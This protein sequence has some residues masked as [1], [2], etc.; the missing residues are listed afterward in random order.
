MS[1]QA[2]FSQ[3][4]PFKA[5]T[6][7]ILNILIHSLYTEREIFLRELISNASDAL[8]R[9]EFEQLTNRDI[10]DPELEL[11]IW[12]SADPDKRTIFIKDTGLGM[13]AEEMMENLGTIAHSG[14][15][16]FLAAAESG[17]SNETKL[18]DIIGQFGVG[19]YSLFMVAESVRVT[20][21]S[22]R[23]D[24]QASAWTSAGDDT[25]TIEPAEKDERG[26]MIEVHLLE[27]ASEFAQENRLREIIHKHS[28]FVPYPIY[29]GSSEEQANERT[30]LWRQIPRQLEEK[31]YDEFY[32]QL[33]LDYDNPLSYTH[34]AADAPVQ[35]YSILYVPS[36]L[37]RG[38]FSLRKEDGLKLYARKILIQ[39]YCKDLL[40]E[41]LQFIQGV[42]DSEDLPLNVSRESIQ[43]NRVME[44]LKRLITSKAIDMLKKLAEED[45]ETYIKF[46]NEFGRHLKQGIAME[47]TDTSE[48]QLL[49]RF[50]TTTHLDSWSSLDDY[51][52]RL[53]DNQTEIYYILG[54]NEQSVLYSPHLDI[55]QKYN[56]E[57]V[58]MT[59]PLDSF[60][61]VRLKE[62]KGHPLRN[63]AQADLKI[64]ETAETASDEE[65]PAIPADE[66]GSLI[67]RFKR[68]LGEKIQDVRMTDRLADSP[69]RL[70]DPEG[71]PN[72]EM[73]RVYKYLQ[74][75]FEMPAKILE[76][77][78]RH[79]ILLKLSKLSEEDNRNAPI[80]DQIYEN[81]L[82]I[83]GLLKDPA[84][85]INR[86]Q[87]IIESALE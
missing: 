47:M 17:K 71:S 66:W 29:L 70:V 81:A 87:Q 67:D 83:E 63:V 10:R 27:D 54:D 30:A 6:K 80:I 86:I 74:Q 20:S 84:Q 55:F 76:L 13:T 58:L 62:Y 69:A 39:E 19:F 50:H 16:A 35:L 26:T 2:E 23:L 75:E 53:K 68:Q 24:A 85:M 41:Y 12:I 44:Q 61:L 78:P 51:I 65:V 5:E 42:V 59:D 32:K 34:L 8:T 38:L 14:A 7:Q 36:K 45:V 25:F 1:D 48:L 46:W 33:T 77:N 9:L 4:I 52:D 56:K 11:G 40:P 18:S 57:V 64:P 72:Q 22:Y 3:P 31:D 37:E 79:P 43:S 73:Q 82:L 15:R 21:L 49:L 60:M 28:D